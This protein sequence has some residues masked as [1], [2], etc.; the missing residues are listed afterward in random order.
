MSEDRDLTAAIGRPAAVPVR[1][2]I[3]AA[4]RARRFEI[5]WSQAL[6]ARRL[7]VCRNAVSQWEA[8]TR[9]PSLAHLH[10][11]AAVLGKQV[12]VVMKVKD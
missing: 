5:G 4:L 3:V 8:G 6:L 10:R 7:C 9:N 12:I 1:D 2:P 11:W